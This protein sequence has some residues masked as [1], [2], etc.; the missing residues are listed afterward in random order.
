MRSLSNR[1][2][3]FRSAQFAVDIPLI[4]LVVSFLGISIPFVKGLLAGYLYGKGFGG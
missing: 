2:E 3:L 4:V 1:F